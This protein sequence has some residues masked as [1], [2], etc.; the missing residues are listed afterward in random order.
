MAK[1]AREKSARKKRAKKAREKSARKKRAKK[2]RE[3]SAQYKLAITARENIVRK[4]GAKNI[5]SADTKQGCQVFLGTAYQ[6]VKKYTKTGKTQ[7]MAI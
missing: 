7:Q 2:A 5:I 4:R 1:K 6:N 3:N